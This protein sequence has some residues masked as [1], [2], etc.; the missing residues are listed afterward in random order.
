M[1][2]ILLFHELFVY[3]FL[4][5]ALHP[6]KANGVSGLLAHEEDSLADYSD[7]FQGY[8]VENWA[9][10]TRKRYLFRRRIWSFILSFVYACIPL[11]S[12]FRR[13][14]KTKSLNPKTPKPRKFDH[15]GLV[16]SQD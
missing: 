6:G 7:A 3:V 10:S 13:T 14:T 15:W 8:R 4:I 9:R 16:V 12:I 11:Y 2:P 1:L 5:V